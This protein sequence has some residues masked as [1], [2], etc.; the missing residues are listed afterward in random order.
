M[1]LTNVFQKFKISIN[2]NME[3][4]EEMWPPRDPL[5]TLE[6]MRKQRIEQNEYLNKYVF[7]FCD[8]VNSKFSNLTKISE[9]AYG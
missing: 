5:P 4:N 9:G 8:N 1:I 2:Y 7:P 3:D 6:E